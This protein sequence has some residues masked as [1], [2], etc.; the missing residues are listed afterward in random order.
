MTFSAKYLL[1][2]LILLPM[3]SFAQIAAAEVKDRDVVPVD[4]IVKGFYLSASAGPTLLFH[5]PASSGPSPTSL[6]QIVKIGFGY[7]FAERMSLGLFVAVTSNRAGTDYIG[8][9]GGTASGD[10]A[11]LLP[12]AELKV[13]LVGFQDAIQVKRSWFYVKAGVGYLFLY[14]QALLPDRDIDALGGLG[15]EYFTHLRHFSIGLEALGMYWI[16]QK[17]YGVALMPTLRYAF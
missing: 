5:P 16:R 17:T 7:D 15:F 3:P 4:E 10:F 1:T 12:G 11:S 8:K 6:G 13:N 2:A 14:P 9:S